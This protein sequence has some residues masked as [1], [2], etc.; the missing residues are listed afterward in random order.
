MEPYRP[1]VDQLVVEICEDEVP[2]MLTKELK[3]QL[4]SI[5][6]LDVEID[7]QRHPL[8]VAVSLTASSLLRC[9]EGEIRKI[10]Y[11]LLR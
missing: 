8:M 9:F 4:L 10:S 5:P 11:P 3:V 7:G 2:T 1:Y 6:T